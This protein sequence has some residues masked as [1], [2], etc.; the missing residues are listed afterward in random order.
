MIEGGF[1]QKWID[2]YWPKNK[3]GG[4]IIGEANALS[5]EDTA[6]CFI[7]LLT[8]I[9]S[10]IAMLLIENHKDKIKSIFQSLVNEL[11]TKVDT[12]FELHDAERNSK[13]DKKDE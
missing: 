11:R 10:G 4:N 7:I 8:G 5:L 9:C 13:N 6:G 12:K 3:C 1:L 2:R